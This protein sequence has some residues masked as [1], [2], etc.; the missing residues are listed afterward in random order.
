MISGE[1]VPRKVRYKE[2]RAPARERQLYDPA[3]ELQYGRTVAR[4]DKVEGPVRPDADI[5]VGMLQKGLLPASGHR[6]LQGQIEPVLI[7]EGKAGQ[8]G[9]ARVICFHPQQETVAGAEQE[10]P[11]I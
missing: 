11:Y 1:P 4:R 7:R 2:F 10:R 9:M 6:K 5:P 3:R 8:K